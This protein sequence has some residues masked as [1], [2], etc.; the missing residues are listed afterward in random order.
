MNLKPRE[1]SGR[2]WSI[3]AKRPGPVAGCAQKRFLFE[4]PQFLGFDVPF[5]LS[6]T[7]KSSC[8]DLQYDNRD[9]VS[10]RM[11]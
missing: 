1:A 8:K 5:F 10:F 6:T 2:E 11:F 3:F 4:G 7:Y 9:E